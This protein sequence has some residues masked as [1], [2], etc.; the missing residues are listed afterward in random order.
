M[1][2]VSPFY[3]PADNL[4]VSSLRTCEPEIRQQFSSNYRKMRNV[5]RRAWVPTREYWVHHRGDTEPT[6]HSLIIYPF[7]G[8]SQDAAVCHTFLFC[9]KHLLNTIFHLLKSNV[10]NVTRQ[11]ILIRQTYKNLSNHSFMLRI[12]LPIHRYSHLIHTI[13]CFW[14]FE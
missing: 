7:C 6:N 5:Q 13:Q 11:Y 3:F 9:F 12:D 14:S 1:I 2:L 4:V 10:D 8:S